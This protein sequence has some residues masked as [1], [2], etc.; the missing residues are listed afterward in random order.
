M[1]TVVEA[2]TVPRVLIA[3]SDPWAREMLNELVLNVRCDAQLDICANGR[4]AVELMRGY[5]P[6]LVIASR[7]LPGIDGLSLLRTLRQLRRQPPVRFIL[8]SSRND[9]AS[10]REAVQ[11]AP[12]AYLTKPLN[13]ESLRQRL[14]T[15]LLQDGAQVACAVPALE[16]GIGLDAFLEKRRE[17][18]DGGPL[19]VDVAAAVA[20][21][22]G[23][24]GV[25]LKLLEQALAKDPHITALLIAAASSATQHQGKPVQNLGRALAVLGAPQSVNL[26]QGIALK[27]GAVLTDATL[28][29]HATEIWEVSQRTAECARTLARK[30]ELDHERCYCAG[31]L[32]GLGDL[33]VV[34]C[35]QDW[36]HAGGTLDE[37]TIRRTLAQ[38]SAS[39]GSALRTRWRLPLELRELVAAVYQYNTGVFTREV[40]AMNVAGQMGLLGLEDP[41]EALAKSKSARLLKISESDLEGMRRR[42]VA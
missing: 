31:L 26:I 34:R 18:A 2:L 6:D 21:S 30:L 13:I 20:S 7:E 23:A 12:T 37:A 24:S 15:L 38:Y 29:L 17:V 5:I 41:L 10:V 16:A 4:E 42:T 19:F 25:D 39:F 27:R 22:R 14:E 8:L 11:L 33:T 36:L 3:E 1:M 35:L 28:L 40:L 32:R 9:S